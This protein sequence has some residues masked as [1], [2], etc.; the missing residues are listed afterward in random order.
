M[1]YIKPN[2]MMYINALVHI[3]GTTIV[4]SSIVGAYRIIVWVLYV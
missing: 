1:K 2:T 4:L 3:V